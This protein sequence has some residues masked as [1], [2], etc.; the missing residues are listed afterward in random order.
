MYTTNKTIG[1]LTFFKFPVK[2]LFLSSLKHQ[3][4]ERLSTI[5]IAIVYEIDH[6]KLR[7][8][9]SNVM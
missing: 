9:F 3:L 7:T 8:V 2:Q 6:P 5:I 1:N 4:N